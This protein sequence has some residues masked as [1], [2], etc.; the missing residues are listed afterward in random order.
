MEEQAQPREEDGQAEEGTEDADSRPKGASRV[1]N[2]TSDQLDMVILAFAREK[3]NSEECRERLMYLQADFEN[4][5][6]RMDRE[7]N[8]TKRRT[9]ESVYTNL[10]D[11]LDELEL[12]IRNGRA[13]ESSATLLEGVE[14]T[15]KK[16]KKMLANEGICEIASVGQPFDPKFH[17]AVSTGVDDGCKEGTV[18]GEMRKGYQ[19]NGRVLRPAMVKVSVKPG[20]TENNDG[21]KV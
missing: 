2:G 11:A 6:K 13:T 17:S 10:F 14:M 12:A 21:E 20:S 1:K 19:I 4:Y 15:L 9:T 8:E 5:R 16:M 3:K 18:I 7:I